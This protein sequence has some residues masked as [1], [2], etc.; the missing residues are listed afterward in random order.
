MYVIG[1][2]LTPYMLPK[3]VEI[4]VVLMTGAFLLGFSVLFIGPFYEEKNLTVMCVGLF[5]SGSLLGPI[6]IPNMAEMMF[7]TKIHYPAGDLEHANS[8][9][10]GIL[11]CCYG[12][13]GA[14][15]PLMGASL[16]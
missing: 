14:L 16:Y 6:M 5:V 15:G 7:A 3:W 11:N 1:T 8:L 12:A 4:R 10:S 9:L 2:L 13:G